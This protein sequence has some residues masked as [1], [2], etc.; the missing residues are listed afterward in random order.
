MMSSTS[1]DIPLS[2][3]SSPS[4]RFT[5]VL[6]PR[7]NPIRSLPNETTLS[8]HDTT[9][10]LYS[11]I[12][13][14]ASLSPNRLRITKGSDGSVVPNSR[15]LTLSQVPLYHRSTLSVKDLGPQIAWRTVFLIEYAGPLLIHPLIWFARETLYPY[16]SI[17]AASLGVQPPSSAQVA[18]LGCVLAHFAKRELETVF[19]HRFSAATMPLRNLFKNS[20]HYWFLAGWNLAY[21]SY[22]PAAPRGATGKIKGTIGIDTAPPPPPL[23]VVA[24]LG[25]TLFAVAEA[26]NLRTHLILRS[27]RSE[28][29][30]TRGI[31]R[32]WDFDL[33]TCPNYMWELLAW[34]GIWMVNESWATALFILVAGVQMAMWARKKE[35]R[36]RAEFGERYKKKR[37]AMIPFVL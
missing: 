10:T 34:V 3:L 15:T 33:V 12:A 18:T 29:S 7:G 20:L 25:V 5:L 37:F 14:Q 31:P 35:S 24:A 17:N 4:D 27:L 9:Q 11:S 16:T 19:V 22:S 13:L 36:Y 21:W 8:P 28:G 30:T 6:Q 23:S 26:M 2:S 1:T 32:G